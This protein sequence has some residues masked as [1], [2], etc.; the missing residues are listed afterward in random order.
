MARDQNSTNK[1]K[2]LELE[3]IM[4]VGRMNGRVVVP[5]FYDVDPSEVRHQKG[6]F[7]KAFEE[8]LSTISVDESTYSNWRRQL[9]D[10]GGIAGFVLVGSR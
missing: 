1:G 5:V 3:K 2:R 7:G 8:L 4:E 10:I 6:R 9:F